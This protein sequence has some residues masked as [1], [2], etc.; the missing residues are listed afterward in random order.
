M[1]TSTTSVLI[2][3]VRRAETE[4]NRKEN[5]RGRGEKRDREGNNVMVVG[6]TYQRR[7]LHRRSGKNTPVIEAQPGKKYHHSTL[8]CR[9]V[10][11]RYYFSP[12]SNNIWNKTAM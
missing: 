9:I 11:P 7:Q 6:V 12:V 3:R 1:N 10:L 8:T 2:Y 4:R 5:G